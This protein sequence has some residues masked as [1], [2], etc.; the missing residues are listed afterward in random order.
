[1]A[2][3]TKSKPSKVERELVATTEKLRARL[4]KTQAKAEAWKSE[5]KDSAKAVASLEK[6]LVRQTR[7]AD[8]AKQ[9]AK[10]QKQARKVVEASVE[11]TSAELA[12]KTSEQRAE[13]VAEQDGRPSEETEAQES[14]AAGVPANEQVPDDS[15]PVTKLRAEARKQG[16]AGYSRKT[17]AQLLAVLR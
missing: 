9:K 8:N 7:L 6:K 15:W 1:M 10:A 13:Q 5:A 2:K 16:L 14:T 12:E 17:K 4:A 11:Q 3:K